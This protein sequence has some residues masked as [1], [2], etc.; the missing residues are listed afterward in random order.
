LI[1]HIRSTGIFDRF[2]FGQ[3]RDPCETFF[4]KMSSKFIPSPA[5][6]EPGAL[7]NIGVTISINH[8]GLG[9]GKEGASGI[10]SL[11]ANS[12]TSSHRELDPETLEPKGYAEQTKLHPELRGPFSAAHVQKDPVTG[13]FFNYNLDIGLPSTYRVFRVSPATG[14]TDILATIMDA[15][16]AY[17]HSF[18]LTENCIVLCIW[19]SHFTVGAKLMESKNF[20]EAIDDVDPTKPTQWYVIDRKHGKGVLSKYEGDA[21]FC[22][23]TMN[24]WEEPSPTD[25]SQVDIVAELSTYENLDVIKRLY[26][27]HLKSTSPVS[28]TYTGVNGAKTRSNIQRWRLPKVTAAQSSSTNKAVLD[29]SAPKEKS[30]ELPA[31]NPN[32]TY[33]PSRYIYGTTD[34]G[35]STFFDGLLKYDTQTHDVLIWSQHGHS[36]GEPIFV[37][38]P[39]GTR[40]DDGVLLSVVLDGYSGKSYL[41]VLDAKSLTE[42]GR[43]SM[44]WAVG[45]G[46]H[47]AHYSALDAAPP[48]L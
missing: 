41:V 4:K 48:K 47:G 12:D 6:Q 43:A 22:F 40:E 46:F 33:K 2:S 29:F 26:Y 7:S 38:N 36:G 39:E 16:P 35:L 30:C 32:Y 27:D 28:G 25:P 5:T 20:F 37:P 24:S 17:L 9:G 19:G 42:I 45:F 14:E 11:W 8:P 3:K 1:E 15:P 18:F 13:E 23:H 21:F 31:F 44:D 34:R 10:R